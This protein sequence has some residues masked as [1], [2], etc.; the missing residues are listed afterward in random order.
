MCSYRLAWAHWCTVLWPFE[1]IHGLQQNNTLHYVLRI[2]LMNILETY[3]K[4]CV[5]HIHQP[6]AELSIYKTWWRSLFAYKILH[7]QISAVNGQLSKWH[8]STLFL[9]ESM[10]PYTR[11]EGVLH[12]TRHMILASQYVCVWHY[13][14]LPV[15]LIK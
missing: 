10:L 9:P 8:S 11:L 13:Y 5:Q 3:S 6:W 12:D 4:Y 7:L 15:L 14:P 1:P 2:G